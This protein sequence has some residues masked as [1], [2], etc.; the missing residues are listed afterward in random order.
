MTVLGVDKTY[1]LGQVHVTV[2][3]FKNLSVTNR[4][5]RDHPIFIGPILI[6]GNSDYIVYSHFFGHIKSVIKHNSNNYSLPI[7]GSDQEKSIIQA[8]RDTLQCPHINCVRHLIENS[9]RYMRD[10][11]GLPETVRRSIK[12]I[13]YGE[14]G[15][16]TSQTDAI[17]QI[18]K[19]AAIDL[20]SQE[21]PQFLEYFNNQTLPLIRKNTEI[22]RTYNIDPKWNNNNTESI[23]YVLK[24]HIDWKPQSLI[25]L[26]KSLRD[27]IHYQQ[28]HVELS[29]V[30][31]GDYQLTPEY[32]RFN[33]LSIVWHNQTQEQREKHMVRFYNTVTL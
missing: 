13:V 28:S 2:T 10:K 19:S 6:H 25:T 27:V 1:N 21:A 17:F 31:M 12:S 7:I 4:K 23:N 29:I 9:I 22:A 15:L 14:N 3:T 8:V 33:M 11:I 5:T 20:I 16:I 30:E 32:N 18:R 24:Q 26:I